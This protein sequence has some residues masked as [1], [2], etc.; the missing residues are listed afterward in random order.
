MATHPPPP[1][2]LSELVE[3][4]AQTAQA[5]LDLAATCSEEDF[6]QPSSCP[7]WTVKDHV[8]HVSGLESALDGQVDPDV[9]VP[10]YPWLR[11][12][13]GRHMEQAVEVRR[14]W[15]GEEV[16]AELK[17]VIPR[18]LEFLHSSG[19]SLDSVIPGPFAPMPASVM[20]PIRIIDIWCHEQDLRQALDRPGNLDSPGAALF[21]TRVMAA[22]PGRAVDEAGVPVGAAVILESTGPVTA[23]EGIRVVEN[24][25]GTPAAEP[26]FAGGSGDGVSHVGEQVTT[27]R[28]STEALT[29]RGAGRIA[30]DDLHY[31]AEGDEQ[32]AHRLLDALAITP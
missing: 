16:V 9:E 20:L 31:T 23:R 27:I 3:A 21:V 18:R 6:A 22:L 12:D 15:S 25:D 30:T 5:V 14:L 32:L 17:R 24:E 28:M 19:L 8:S 13:M 26:L 7:G 2:Q 11:H 29:R 10:D 1:E 4:Y